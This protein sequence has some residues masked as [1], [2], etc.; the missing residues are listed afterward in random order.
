MVAPK[1]FSP[2]LWEN[3]KTGT[4]RMGGKLAAR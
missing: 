3:A 4:E 2:Q 1:A